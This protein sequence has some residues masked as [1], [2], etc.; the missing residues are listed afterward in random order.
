MELV[1][2]FLLFVQIILVCSLTLFAL[3][4]G[5]EALSSFLPLLA[6]CMNLFVVKQITLFGLQIT[7]SEGLAVG[8]LLGFNLMQEFFGKEAAKKIIWLTFLSSTT[9][10]LLSQLHLLFVP[11]SFDS[12]QNHFAAL[13][14]LLPRLL[15]ASLLS[16]LVV[17][18][19]DLT[20]FTY[21]KKRWRNKHLTSRI[22]ISLLLSQALDTLLFSFL[23][24]YGVVES[25][26]HVIFFSF[27]IKVVV[28]F[29]ST[30]CATIAKR[31]SGREQISI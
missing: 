2:V 5:K 7:C 10:I 27:F 6:I 26:F 21:L 16:F 29:F 18:L 31:I 14:P 22:S 1:N 9:F 24:L 4:L 3:K 15:I 30:P 19:I 13:F 28:I 8:Y 23:A 25:L 17:Q 20:F 12:S 11:N